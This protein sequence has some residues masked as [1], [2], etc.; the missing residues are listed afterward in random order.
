LGG[1]IYTIKKNT[2]TLLVASKEI[3][4]DIN[5]DTTKYMAMSRDQ[6]AGKSHNMK[7]DNI[8]F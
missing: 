7:T 4:L 2:E 1:S 5:A 3:V 6:D 8:S